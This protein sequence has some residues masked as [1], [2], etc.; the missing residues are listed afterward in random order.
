MPTREQLLKL[1]RDV[2]FPLI[3][4]DGGVLFLVSYDEGDVHLHLAGTCAGCPGVSMTRDRVLEP[5]LQALG[6]KVKL[7]LTAGWTIPPRA[8][9]IS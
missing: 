1:C 7:K 9:K 6:P 4:A 5:V 2:L 3:A 8:E